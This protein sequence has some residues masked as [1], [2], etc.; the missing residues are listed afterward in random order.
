[1][2][3]RVYPTLVLVVAANVTF[4]LNIRHGVGEQLA[5]T[6]L[7]EERSLQI[8]FGQACQT[9]SRERTLKNG[10]CARFAEADPQV[11]APFIEEAQQLRLRQPPLIDNPG[12][13]D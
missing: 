8:I 1:M 5:I 4:L 12:R 2:S 3:R 13:K 9:E 11:C 6:R 10:V 7:A